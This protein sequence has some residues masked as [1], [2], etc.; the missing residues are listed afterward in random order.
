MKICSVLLIFGLVRND[1]DI[2][3]YILILSL[4]T[5]AGNLTL[6]PY[7]KKYV[8]LPK[9][10]DL[11]L[12]KHLVPSLT[13]FIPQIATQVYVVLNKTMLG[14]M[15]GVAS[16]GYFDYAD[17]I[18]KIVLAMVTAIGTVMLPRMAHTFAKRDFAKLH[19]YLYQSFQF[20]SFL[21]VGMLFGLAG[22]AGKF[23]PWFMGRQFTITGTIIPIES[24]VI[25]AIAWSN[26]LGTQYLIPTGQNREYTISVVSGAV[27]NLILNIPLIHFFGVY[28]ATVSTVFSEFVVT[29]SQLFFLR[30]EISIRQLFD[31]VWKLLFSGICMFIVVLFM[32]KNMAPSLVNFGLQFV[33]GLSL[34]LLVNVVVGSSTLLLFKEKFF[35]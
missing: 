26:V 7:L 12:R 17:K 15:R 3:V 31:G 1:G 29:G 6:W 35:S 14:N 13:L 33:V 8:D 23:A 32:N 11:N 21:S 25:V 34:Y 18:V 4:S 20:V 5:L 27:A 2:N 9:I 30:K 16:A 28:G 10:R 22:M 19:F 24:F